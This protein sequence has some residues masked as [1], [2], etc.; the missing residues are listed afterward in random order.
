MTKTYENV[1][2]KRGN[3]SR[4]DGDTF[5]DFDIMSSTS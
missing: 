5:P 4:F 3:V 2:L 1:R